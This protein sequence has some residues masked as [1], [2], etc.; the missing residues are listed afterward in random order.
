MYLN[1]P[2]ASILTRY[3]E[4]WGYFYRE[5]NFEFF[6]QGVKNFLYLVEDDLQIFW[7]MTL[8]LQTPLHSVSTFFFFQ[9]NQFHKNMSPIFRPNLRTFKKHSRSNNFVRR[10]KSKISEYTF[11]VIKPNHFKLKVQVWF[12]FPPQKIIR[13]LLQN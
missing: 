11:K 2:K 9:K 12:F 4:T 10:R 13:S 1:I 7:K 6:L 5:S 3:K 8:K